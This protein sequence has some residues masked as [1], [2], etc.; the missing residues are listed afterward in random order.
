MGIFANHYIEY[1]IILKN[2]E[3][4]TILTEKDTDERLV[5]TN[6]YKK[7]HEKWFEKSYTKNWCELIPNNEIDDFVLTEQ[8]KDLIKTTLKKN[9]GN[10][11]IHGWFDVNSIG[12]SYGLMS[13]DS[14]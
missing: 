3:Q 5:D 8:E 13:L 11:R 9:E 14:I 4:I 6:Y 7:Q 2:G 1:I 10:V 12:S